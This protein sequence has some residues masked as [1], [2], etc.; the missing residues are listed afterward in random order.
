MHSPTRRT[1]RLRQ[2]G[3]GPT[4]PVEGRRI[5]TRK[6]LRLAVQ[7]AAQLRG[8]SRAAHDLGIEHEYATTDLM[9]PLAYAHEVQRLPRFGTYLV[10]ANHMASS[11]KIRGEILGRAFVVPVQ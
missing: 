10:S 8:G 1:S 5:E 4:Y 9:Q 7:E 2:R 3:M 11:A 6:L